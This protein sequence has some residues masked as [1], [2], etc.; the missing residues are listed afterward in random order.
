MNMRRK[1]ELIYQR[2]KSGVGPAGQVMFDRD[3]WLAAQFEALERE[4]DKGEK[5]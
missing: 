3:R 1:L 5:A 2:W 4:E